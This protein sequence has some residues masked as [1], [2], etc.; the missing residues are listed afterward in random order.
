M[1]TCPIV[2]QYPATH[3]FEFAGHGQSPPQGNFSI[4]L[5]ADQLLKHSIYKA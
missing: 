1:P 3:Y 4:D 5:F 2:A